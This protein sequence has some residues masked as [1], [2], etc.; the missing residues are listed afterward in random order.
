VVAHVLV[1]WVYVVWG[2]LVTPKISASAAAVA[3]NPFVTAQEKPVATK[4]PENPFAA[5]PVDEKK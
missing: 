4:P 5:R 3:K 1:G 2:V